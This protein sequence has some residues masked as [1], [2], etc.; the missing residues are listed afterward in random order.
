[1]SCHSKYWKH[2]AFPI[3]VM[4]ISVLMEHKQPTRESTQP[5]CC[6][7]IPHDNSVHWV[8]SLCVSPLLIRPLWLIITHAPSLSLSYLPLHTS[9]SPPVLTAAG[10][11]RGG[12]PTFF[13]LS[14][15]SLCVLERPTS[16]HRS[17]V[18]VGSCRLASTN[19]LCVC[20][21]H[22]P[23]CH[24][25]YHALICHVW[26]FLSLLFALLNHIFLLHSVPTFKDCTY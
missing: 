15:Q 5:I 16:F 12:M 1:M 19:S 11:S 25:L 4:V 24:I 2:L 20:A 17:Q 18:H 26:R 13:G 9:V 14:F 23:S 7:Q 22:V 10:P 21:R 6:T 8:L 3:T